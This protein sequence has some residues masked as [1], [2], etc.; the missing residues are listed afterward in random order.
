MSAPNPPASSQTHCHPDIDELDSAIVTL[1]ARINAA[2][3][4]LLVLVRRFD[5]RGGWLRW[6]F[7]NCTE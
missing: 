1:A 5:E 4:E 2:S 6:G 3:Y 7:P